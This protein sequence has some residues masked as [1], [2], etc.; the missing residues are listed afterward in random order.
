VRWLADEN[1]DNDILRGVR[2]RGADFDFV[3]VQDISG[4][5]GC[6]DPAVLAWATT[7]DRAALT[8]DLSTMIPAMHKQLRLFASCAPIVLVPRSLPISRVID[9][10]LLLDECSVGPDWASA[11]IYLPLG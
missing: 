3:R 7:N 5:S 11:V 8:H 2:R 10:L 9:D 1:F 6:D 4:I